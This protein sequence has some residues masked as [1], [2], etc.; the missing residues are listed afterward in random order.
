MRGRADRKRHHGGSLEP[1]QV[2]QLR[3]LGGGREG[4]PHP[5]PGS[6]Q[7]LVVQLRL[8]LVYLVAELDVVVVHGGEV[9]EVLGGARHVGH[10]REDPARH[11]VLVTQR[12]REQLMTPDTSTSILMV[13]IALLARVVLVWNL[14]MLHVLRG[15]S[16]GMS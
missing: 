12:P 5:P 10:L 3:Q 6:C 13:S 9:G 1:G 16:G 2:R 7:L 8:G 14:W 15:T 4:R 11:Q